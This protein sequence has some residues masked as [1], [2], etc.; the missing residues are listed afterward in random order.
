MYEEFVLKSYE[1]LLEVLSRHNVEIVIFR[2]YANARLLLP[3][4][5][6]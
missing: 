1:P 5:L 3:S 6:K 2:T 4:I